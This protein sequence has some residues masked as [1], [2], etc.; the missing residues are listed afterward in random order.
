[1]SKFDRLD[2]G[3]ITH[4]NRDARL[5]S[6]RLARILGVSERTVHN[7]IK[8]LTAANVIQTVAVI[9]PA[10]FGYTMTVLVFCDIEVGYQDQAAEAILKL[11]EVD[12]L[13]ISTGDQDLSL[14]ARFRDSEQMQE[15][16]TQKLHQI[17]GMRRTRTA[18]IPRILKDTHQWL[19]PDQAFDH[20]SEEP[21]S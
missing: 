11:P 13:A 2:K 18:L 14:R 6:A 9:N 7:R 16:I 15:F 12:Y 1:L 17:P 20:S 19:P 5:S 4:L 10:A 3:I 21:T 8:R